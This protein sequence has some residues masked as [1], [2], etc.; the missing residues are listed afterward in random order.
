MNKYDYGYELT[1]DTTALWAYDKIKE[2]SVVLELGPSNGNLVYHLT[3][4]KHC[5]ADIV[6]LDAEA[7]TLAARF[8]RNSCIG[9]QEG[10]LEKDEWF[11][12]LKENRY[13]HI[14][15][16]DVLEHLRKPEKVLEKLRLLLK[17]SGSILIS[18]PNIAHNSVLLNLLQNRFEYSSVGLLDDTHLHFF[19]Y[20]SIKQ[21]LNENGFVTARE[22]VR[23][24][25]VGNNEVSATYGSLGSDVEAFLKTRDLGTAYQ[26]LFTVQKGSEQKDVTLEY[27]GEKPYEIVVFD[28][29]S[30][31]ILCRQS[32]NPKER[33]SLRI[34][35]LPGQ[36]LR[37][38]PLNA[39]CI[40]TDVSVVGTRKDG[41]VQTVK[42][43]EQTGNCFR[44]LYV[45]YDGD[46]QIYVDMPADVGEIVFSCNYLCFDSEA[47]TQMT[48]VRDLVRWMEITI[49][50]KQ[51]ILGKKE[52]EA[53]AIRTEN[54]KLTENVQALQDQ[55]TVL[56]DR[57]K[58]L[59]IQIAEQDKITENLK[60]ELSAIGASVWGK[61]YYKIKS[62]R[63]KR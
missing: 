49:Q 50:E 14:V 18:V 22:E 61:M 62:I 19:T 54:Q 44:D 27:D 47:L 41:E 26:F 4:D 39:N 12:L 5:I 31:N 29:E 51:E 23:T 43:T 13:D 2:D 33:I 52:E 28:G 57:V 48:E 16:L 40:L 10:D 56:N 55:N 32:I 30:S 34:Q 42:I 15:L 38:D 6:E 35:A 58:H 36:R 7:G 46:P 60:A 53:V 9:A 63:G 8:C 3:R 21:L 24:I 25:P 17:D 45:F 59:D 20:Q 37:I 11:Q 1:E